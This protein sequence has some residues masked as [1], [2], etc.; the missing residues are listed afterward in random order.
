MASDGQASSLPSPLVGA[1]LT[2]ELFNS[3][4]SRQFLKLPG[5]LRVA[6]VEVGDPTGVPVIMETGLGGARLL[7]LSFIDDCRDTGVRLIAFDE[8]GVG[9]SGELEE[10]GDAVA[11][12]TL[13]KDVVDITLAIAD[14]LKL[15][16]FGLFAFSLGTVTA[17]TIA[18]DHADRIIGP[19]QLFSPF[20]IPPSP[21]ISNLVKVGAAVNASLIRGAF[22][23]G[24]GIGGDPRHSVWKRP[25][26]N[27][28]EQMGVMSSSIRST[29]S[30]CQPSTGNQPEEDD[31]DDGSLEEDKTM[32]LPHHIAV[33][34]RLEKLEA[35]SYALSR[36]PTLSTTEAEETVRKL[37]PQAA[38]RDVDVSAE[39]AAE[40]FPRRPYTGG[41]M[42]RDLLIGLGKA[43]KPV[44][45]PLEVS[46]P[47][48]VW[49]GTADGLVPLPAARALAQA[50][51]NAEMTEKAT[52]PLDD[53]RHVFRR[54]AQGKTYLTSDDFK[55]AMTGLLG[56]KPS[57]WERA[58]ACKDVDMESQ[59]MTLP[60]FVMVASSKLSHQDPD[61]TIRHAFL[62]TD[63]GCHGFITHGDAR[64]LFS[65]FH[66]VPDH[67]VDEAFMLV[68]GNGDGRIT[69]KEFEAMMKA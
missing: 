19:A 39:L 63:V 47:C 44:Y 59:G 8:P 12:K 3:P 26:V 5:G 1:A 55:V 33:V 4:R 25:L 17:L 18:K 52:V 27:L 35:I 22:A 57:K 9:L 68:D 43:G 7:A 66:S 20:L 15:S 38:W 13:F 21:G 11:A 45:D 56:Y 48:H 10:E 6:F 34:H 30:S 61:S 16:K 36:D 40:T 23:M 53:I 65:S 49:H 41:G 46:A 51:P 50:L 31:E 62:A 37:C 14:H 58:H 42:V 60:T 29:S 24:L 54:S 67:V 64:R 2:A 32:R 28:I 69:Y